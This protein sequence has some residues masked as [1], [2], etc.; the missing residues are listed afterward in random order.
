MPRALITGPRP[1]VDR[2]KAIGGILIVGGIVTAVLFS[3]MLGV[4]VA[5]LGLVAFIGLVRGRR[6]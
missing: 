6:Y 5:L 3:V 2:S 1:V 4:V